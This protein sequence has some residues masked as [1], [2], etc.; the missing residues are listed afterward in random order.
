MSNKNYMHLLEEQ[1]RHMHNVD[2]WTWYYIWFIQV[3]VN[4]RC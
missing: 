2:L 3:V 1:Q 4:E